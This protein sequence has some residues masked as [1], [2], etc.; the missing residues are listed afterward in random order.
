MNISIS[1]IN[2]IN[3]V[4]SSLAI[5]ILAYIIIENEYREF[6]EDIN[7]I[8]SKYVEEQKN[9]IKDVTLKSLKFIK[10]KYMQN[11]P[12]DTILKDIENISYEK[13]SNEYLF[14]Y[15]SKGINILDPVQRGNINKNLMNF[16]DSSGEFVIQKIISVSKSKS[17]NYINYI[18][19]KPLTS[20]SAPKVSYVVYYDKLDW[21]I[22]SGIYLDDVYKDIE[23]KKQSY[24]DKIIKY[25]TGLAGL[26]FFIILS[27]IAIS[28]YFSKLIED[29]HK[30]YQDFFRQAVTVHKPI[31]VDKIWLLESK[32]IAKL[33]NIMVKEIENKTT[34]LQELNN[35]LEDKVNKKTEKL[36]QLLSTQDKFIKNSIHEVNTPLAIIMMNIELYEMKNSKNIYFD[37][38]LAASKII[39]NIY[40]DL[41]FYIK[42][43]Y[44][45]HKK[46][47]IDLSNCLKERIDFFNDITTLN[48]LSFSLSIEE[49]L[50]INM[51]EVE[52]QRIIDNNL[53]NA[54]KYSTIGSA[55]KI[56]LKQVNSQYYL[57]F[58]TKSKKIDNIDKIFDRFYRENQNRGGFGI[59]LSLVKELC[60]ENLI[61]IKIESN[62]EYT[63][64][65][66]IFK[67][68]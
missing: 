39:Q 7:N 5:F 12:I 61:N 64:F 59:G 15:N 53:S 13:G 23:N 37:K 6:K 33:A 1:K 4:I 56:S 31:D 16:Q 50:S 55:I 63:D 11:T 29:E 42:K 58:I 40:T 65:T 51:S 35:T 54:I 22:G 43:D 18:W 52:L 26:S 47:K 46:S 27:L 21:V 19:N 8:E 34:S 36:E 28:K 60:D 48:K 38:I 10:Y 30:L 9:R 24:H 66:Y 3:I 25:V 32:E 57:S 14:I 67:R 41:E 49:N 20:K 44:V 17:G 68:A 62:S 45:E 2:T